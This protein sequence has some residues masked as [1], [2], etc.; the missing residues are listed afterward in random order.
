MTANILD[1]SLH[2]VFGDLSVLSHKSL[3]DCAVSPNPSFAPHASVSDN[4]NNTTRA[5]ATGS[6]MSALGRAKLVVAELEQLCAV[7]GKLDLRDNDGRRTPVRVV[8]VDSSKVS[9]FP[10]LAAVATICYSARNILPPTTECL[11]HDGGGLA[12]RG[13]WPQP[14]GAVLLQVRVFGAA[15]TVPTA[16]CANGATSLQKVTTTAFR[17]LR[18]NAG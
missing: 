12:R 6:G 15:G 7:G 13:E 10:C 9:H 2:E 8:S 11:D 1:E 5:A 3:D 17:G 14:R 16:P 4:E 18:L